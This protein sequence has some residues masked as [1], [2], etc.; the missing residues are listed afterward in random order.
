M[1]AWVRI[2]TADGEFAGVAMLCKPAIGMSHLV[3]VAAASA[4]DL[5]SQE[6]FV[7]F[8]QR[9]MRSFRRRAS[10]SPVPPEVLPVHNI[11]RP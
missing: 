11:A 7:A 5:E 9:L 6:R 4:R 8:D 3:T 2:D 10:N 1:H